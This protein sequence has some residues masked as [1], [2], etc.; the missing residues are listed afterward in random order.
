MAPYE[1][2]TRSGPSTSAPGDGSRT[3][4]ITNDPTRE[5]VQGD[6]QSSRPDGDG[7]VGTLRLR[8]APNRSNRP[9]V[10]WDE[11]V[12]DNEGAGRKK[13]KICCIFHKARKF[14]ESSSSDSDSDSDVDSCHRHNHNHN[15]GGSNPSGNG[16][17]ASGSSQQSRPTKVHELSEDDEPNAYER[18]PGSRKKGKRKAGA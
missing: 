14:D 1:P 18:M 7:I 10:A 12:I 3:L 5:A 8:G 13:S 9:R 4:T 15:H 17:E 2:P 11:G 6:E 16:D